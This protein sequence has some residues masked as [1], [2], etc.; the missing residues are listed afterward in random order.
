MPLPLRADIFSGYVSKRPSMVP[1]IIITV[2]SPVT[3][4]L[5]VLTVGATVHDSPSYLVKT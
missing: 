5:P 2:S 1:H 3:V 4:V